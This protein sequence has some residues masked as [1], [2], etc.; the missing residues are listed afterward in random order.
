MASPRPAAIEP[1]LIRMWPVYTVG[2]PTQRLT[3]DGWNRPS[4]V[5]SGDGLTET[6][7]S[8]GGLARAAGRP[9]A[10]VKRRAARRKNRR[11][12]PKNPIEDLALRA[13]HTPN[14]H[15]GPVRWV[16]SLLEM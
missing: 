13:K 15:L 2:A 7:L 14:P 9:E 6:P 11:P 3:A 4:A 16:V 12:K 5:V 10:R 1:D 8:Q